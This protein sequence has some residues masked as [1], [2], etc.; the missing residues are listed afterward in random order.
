[1]APALDAAGVAL[2]ALSYDAVPILADFAA[3][4]GITYPLLSDEGSHVMRRLGLLNPRV[5]EDHAHYGIAPSPRHVDLPYPGVLVLDEA[6]MV[7]QR[8]FHESYRERDSG[9]GLVARTLGLLVPAGAA[10]AE[11]GDVVR[12]RAALDS[13]TFAF[14]QRLDLTVSLAVAP[15]FH[16]YA[17]PAPG[18]CTPLGVEVAGG[19]G[20]VVGEARWPEPRRLAM[21]GPAGSF[22]AHEGEV[23]ASIPLTFTAP[24]G[25]GDQQLRVTVRYQA[26]NDTACLP[27]AAAVLELAVA[28]APLVGRTL[29][30]RPARN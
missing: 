17:A 22:L 8:R 24:P 13:P 26:C 10:A 6:G 7:V 23:I 25:E 20:L 18:G 29:P 11:A 2:F 15:G 30:A 9:A 28:E 21:G 12:V 3:A 27:P 4:H 16:V 1:M 14:F 19:P 5:Q